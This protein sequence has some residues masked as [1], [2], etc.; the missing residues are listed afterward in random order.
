[1]S[2]KIFASAAMSSS[3]ADSASASAWAIAVR[4]R[5]FLAYCMTAAPASALASTAA[6]RDG[7]FRMASYQRKPSAPCPLM[8]Q[9]NSRLHA[10]RAA[11]AARPHSISHINAAR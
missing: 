6:S 8:T 9:K 7:N 1:M 4:G 3:P 5:Q 11:S 2:E 10:M